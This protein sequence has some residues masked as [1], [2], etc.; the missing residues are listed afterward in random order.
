MKLKNKFY[1]IS[2]SLIIPVT[3]VLTTIIFYQQKIVIY[4]NFEEK[5]LTLIRSFS[6]ASF[7]S[8]AA[9]DPSIFSSYMEQIAEDENVE[10]F[11]ITDSYGKVLLGTNKL[12][13]IKSPRGYLNIKTIKK[14]TPLHQ[15]Y[16]AKDHKIYEISY[17]IQFDSVNW[18]TVSIGF[19][20]ARFDENMGRMLQFLIILSSGLIGIFSL[21]FF[22]AGSKVTA[23]FEK[24]TDAAKKI[25]KGNFS[26][27]VPVSTKDEIGE[28]SQAF[29]QISEALE[30]EKEELEE[31]DKKCDAYSKALKEKIH[32]LSI[33]NKI[34]QTIKALRL[35]LTERE[36]FN[37]ILR[38]SMDISRAKAGYFFR[39]SRKKRAHLE[40]QR[41]EALNFEFIS[42]IAKKA[43]ISKKPVALTQEKEIE[44]NLNLIPEENTEINV[45]SYPLEAKNTVWGV[46]V[47]ALPEKNPSLSNLQVLSSFLQEV[48]LIIENSFLTELI[49]ESQRVDSFN[50]LTSI[51][52]HDLRGTIAK[53]SLSLHNA[54]KYYYEPDFKRDFL[55]TISSSIKKIKSLTDRINERPTSLNLKPHSINQIIR[56]VIDELSLRE[57]DGINL[58]EKYGDIPLLVLDDYYIKK[59]IR[60]LLINACEAMPEGG[61][62]EV[63]S[64]IKYNESFAYIEIKDSGTGMSQEFIN[65]HLF[66]PFVSTKEKGLGLGLY[67]AKEIVHLHGGEIEVE[68]SPG[69]GTL[70]KI[71]LPLFSQKS[72][73]AV[74]RKQ[75]GQY[76]VEMRMISEKQLKEAVQ[77]QTE[78]KRKIGAIL[79]DMG[80]IREEEI[81]KALKKQKEAEKRVIELIL[82]EHV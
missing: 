46:I 74:I 58:I 19:N 20:L 64:Y 45:L 43:A 14:D 40:V 27:K 50:R 31:K 69:K 54:Q 73:E 12:Q 6:I 82:R 71:K 37:L 53:L 49:V 8:L 42:S 7:S 34:N 78:D 41:G 80:Y 28:L 68:S 59:I 24:L 36:K 30:K 17:P 39:C 60:N 9:N 21:I 11:I 38:T 33:I 72:E 18:G 61:K 15:I 25:S 1:L 52:L 29:N 67:L 3:V 16:T 5:S 10:H 65:T 77:V 26:V 70:F 22:L 76:L 44:I 75:L 56:E 47:L 55:S 13:Q 51:I 4:K 35:S 23:P 62:I 66:K 48:N 57:S 79:I 63:S 2:L 32:E 81:K